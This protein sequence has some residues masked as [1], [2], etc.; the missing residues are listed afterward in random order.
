MKMSKKLRDKREQFDFDMQLIANELDTSANY[1]EYISKDIVGIT[2]VDA[3]EKLVKQVESSVEIESFDDNTV[4]Y[5]WEGEAIIVHSVLGEKF[6]IFDDMI[7]KK[8]EEL[9]QQ[10]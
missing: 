5:E 3:F 1:L 9:L 8:I 10:V 6:L 2:F 4:M 7:S